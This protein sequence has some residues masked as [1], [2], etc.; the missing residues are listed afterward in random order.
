MVDK[1]WEF[2]TKGA[3]VYIPVKLKYPSFNFVFL[4]QGWSFVLLL[5][6]YM[7]GCVSLVFPPPKRGFFLGMRFGMDFLCCITL[8]GKGHIL[9][10]D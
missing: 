1:Y 9:N 5:Y 10:S 3:Y 7:L 6:A 2:G 4:T 8:V